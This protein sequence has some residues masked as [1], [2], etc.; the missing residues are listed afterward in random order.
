MAEKEVKYCPLLGGNSLSPTCKEELCMF[1]RDVRH[2]L[3]RTEQYDCVL[4]F[5][6]RSLIRLSDYHI[7][8]L[9]K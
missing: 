1:W 7:F 9:E 8:H 4:A 6:L 2:P 5:G 3:E